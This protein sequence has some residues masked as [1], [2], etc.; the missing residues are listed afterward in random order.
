ML[1][2]SR[3][4]A[5][6]DAMRSAFLSAKWD[7]SFDT[8]DYAFFVGTENAADVGSREKVTASNDSN[9]YGDIVK[10]G[11]ND[12]YRNLTRKVLEMLRWIAT[13]VKCRF[14]LKIDTDT[15]LHIDN[16]V[17]Y[18]LHYRGLKYGGDVSENAQ[19]KIV[20]H[21]LRTKCNCPLSTLKYFAPGQYRT[22][23]GHL[24]RMGLP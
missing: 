9:A 22:L 3:D 5:G 6:R 18:L 4:V 21:P 20:A 19:T 15:H 14:V 8:W 11:V 24:G 7:F 23:V 12:N 16:L 1:F 13:R 10:L 17:R 2:R